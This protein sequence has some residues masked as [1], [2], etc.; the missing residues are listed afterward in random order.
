VNESG[1]RAFGWDAPEK[2]LGRRVWTGFDGREGEIVGVYRDFNYRSL[3]TGVEPLMLTAAPSQFAYVSLK[4]DT[5]DLSG[6]V[7][8]VK[9]VW[10]ERFP[11]RPFE[12]FFLEEDFDR[13]YRAD[14]RTAVLL[15]VFAGL[16]I[17]IACLGLLGLAAYSAQ[18]YTKEIGIRK[19]LGASISSIVLLLT[20]DFARLVLAAVVIGTPVAWLVVSRWLDDFAYHTHL[21]AWSFVLAALAALSVALLTVSYQAIKAA[22]VNPVRSL[23][24]E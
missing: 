16:A 14:E 15:L 6:T 3:H 9:A 20:R 24:R 17:L 7:D 22:T 23:S 13:Q 8:R 18:A 1:V 21:S 19:V 5:R 10:H 11:D 2:A 12:Y 4:L